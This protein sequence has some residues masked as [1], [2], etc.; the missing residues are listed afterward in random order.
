MHPSILAKRKAQ[1]MGRIVQAAQVMDPARAEALQPKGV[2][3]PAAAEMMRLEAIAD[4]LEGLGPV[5]VTTVTAPAEDP[6]P[7]LEDVPAHMVGAPS[8]ED[9]DAEEELFEEKPKK[10]ATRRTK[11]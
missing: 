7:T 5:A 6:R 8:E 9:V 3:D 11:K 4:L 2:K 10:R 1:A